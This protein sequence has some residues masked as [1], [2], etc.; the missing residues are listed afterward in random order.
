MHRPG[1][2]GNIHQEYVKYAYIYIYTLSVLAHAC[3]LQ[4]GRPSA[5]SVSSCFNRIMGQLGMEG[6]GVGLMIQQLLLAAT[7]GDRAAWF[8]ML[9][10]CTGAPCPVLYSCLRFT[11]ISLRIKRICRVLEHRGAG[12]HLNTDQQRGGFHWEC[13][14][15]WSWFVDTCC[16]CIRLVFFYNC[17]IIATHS[18]M[19]SLNKGSESYTSLEISSTKFWLIGP[20]PMDLMSPKHSRAWV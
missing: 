5:H 17:L 18:T 8:C 15:L 14:H 3:C 16:F 1:K 19:K 12:C 6:S 10:R 2:L 4:C 20:G 9:W 11:W 13:V 7:A